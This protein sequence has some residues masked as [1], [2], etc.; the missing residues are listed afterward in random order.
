MTSARIFLIFILLFILAEG[1]SGWTE[2]EVDDGHV[3]YYNPSTKEYLWEKP[4]SH[5]GR[6]SELMQPEIQVS[7][8]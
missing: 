4:E 3:F 8:S 5:D 1:A 2:Y 7:N 6:T